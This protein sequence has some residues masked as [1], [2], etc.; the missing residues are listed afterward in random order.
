MRRPQAGESHTQR[1]TAWDNRHLCA[2][3]C[4]GT[5]RP[6]IAADPLRDG[7]P[8]TLS[9]LP[10]SPMER[11]SAPIMICLSLS[12]IQPWTPRVCY[13]EAANRAASLTGLARCQHRRNRST[14]RD[15]CRV[16]IWRQRYATHMNL[17][18]SVHDRE[19]PADK[20]QPDGRNGWTTQQRRVKYVRTVSCRDNDDTF[21]TLKPSISN[22]ASGSASAHVHRDH[23]PDLR[24]TLVSLRRRFHR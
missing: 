19:H 24:A 3:S 13:R 17:S 14:T 23:H 16:D 12:Q 1:T 21:V 22:P 6:I 18:E 2:G 10:S 5:R 20:P 8:W 7:K 11:R 4:S 15:D 9:A